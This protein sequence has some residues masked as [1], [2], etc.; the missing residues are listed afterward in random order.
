MFSWN[1]LFFNLCPLPL[2]LLLDTTEKSLAPFS[3][4]SN[5][6]LKQ[7]TQGHIQSDFEYLQG[8]RLHNL[9]EQP[10]TVFSHPSGK[11]EKK[12]KIL[13]FWHNVLCFSLSCLPLFLLLRRVCLHH[14]YSPLTAHQMF[15][16][17]D[18]W[19]SYLLQTEQSH[20]LQS[21]A[22]TLDAPVASSS[23]WPFTELGSMCVISPTLGNPV[24]NTAHLVCLTSS[25]QRM[26][27]LPQ[28]A[29]NAVI[30][31]PQEPVCSLLP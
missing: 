25:E 29:G 16:H 30:M 14:L 21:S 5:S 23:L 7:V 15:I 13:M 10:V 2:V 24:L 28:P 6:H 12:N 17:R 9:P 26:D 27:H 11:K 19:E 1:F 8:Q 3:W 31:E 18:A 4:H 20:F 22:H